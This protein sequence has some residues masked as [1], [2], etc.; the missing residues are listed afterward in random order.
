MQVC[1]ETTGEK[2][3][4]YKTVKWWLEFGFHGKSP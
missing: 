4:L 1:G 3:E 2:A